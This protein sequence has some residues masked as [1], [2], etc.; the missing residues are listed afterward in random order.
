MRRAA[1][2][3]RVEVGCDEN[4]LSALFCMP[5]CADGAAVVRDRLTI[6]RGRTVY[7]R[8]HRWKTW[9]VGREESMLELAMSLAAYCWRFKDG[10]RT[11]C[12]VMRRCSMEMQSAKA[13]LLFLVT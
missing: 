5:D 11:K 10:G 6:V 3:T 7:V 12:V 8:R 13:K 1:W 9:R 4:V 2:N